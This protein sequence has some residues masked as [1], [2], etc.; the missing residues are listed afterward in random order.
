MTALEHADVVQTLS[1]TFGEVILRLSPSPKRP[2]SGVPASPDDDESNDVLADIPPPA[3]PGSGNYFQ[4]SSPVSA[5]STYMVDANVNVAVP[6]SPGFVVSTGQFDTRTNPEN[7]LA[8]MGCFAPLRK[9]DE[10][11]VGRSTPISDLSG[12]QPAFTSADVRSSDKRLASPSEGPGRRAGT[13]TVSLTRKQG[14]SL[15]IGPVN[16]NFLSP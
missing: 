11:K 10:R 12:R 13:K 7:L 14:E 6:P 9:A 3:E 1:G 8:L 4:S 15:G 5:A 16:I 2:R